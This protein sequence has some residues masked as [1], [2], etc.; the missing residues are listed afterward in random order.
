MGLIRK[1]NFPNI[2]R[3]NDAAY[4]QHV[5]YSVLSVD[6]DADVMA[7][8]VE[9]GIIFHITPSTPIKR[10][11]IIDALLVAHRALGLRIEFSKS[12]KIQKKVSFFIEFLE[13]D[14]DNPIFA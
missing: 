5:H 4:L 7:N 13:P 3:D 12:L 9:A 2:I 14:T 1:F 10:Q 11:L 6:T 8:R